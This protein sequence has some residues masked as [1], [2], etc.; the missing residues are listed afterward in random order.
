MILR[1]AVLSDASQLYNL[2]KELFTEEN[3]PL[4][5][6]SF[7]YHIE[8]NLLY[9]VEIEGSIAGYILVLIRRAN[10][11]LYS[12]G[13]SEQ[14]RGKKI[15][16]T[17]FENIFKELLTMGFKKTLLEVRTDNQGAI[18]LYKKVGFQIKKTLPSFYLDGCDAYLMEL[19]Q[20]TQKSC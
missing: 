18:A 6:R 16:L 7:V 14:H 11:K 1:K 9:V 13:I 15:A 10:A 3:F 19:E 4:S 5:K 20:N 17:L 12:L 2:E 8:H